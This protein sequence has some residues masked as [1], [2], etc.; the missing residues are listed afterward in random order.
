MVTQAHAGQT[1]WRQCDMKVGR[2]L[3]GEGDWGGYDQGYIVYVYEIIKRY[4]Q[5]QHL[6][7]EW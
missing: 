7:I 1:N 6:N 4:K 2:T 3:G 5:K